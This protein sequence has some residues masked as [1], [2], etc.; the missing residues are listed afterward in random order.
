MFRNSFESP[1]LSDAPD[2]NFLIFQQKLD[3]KITYKPISC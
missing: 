3:W 2:M 1:V